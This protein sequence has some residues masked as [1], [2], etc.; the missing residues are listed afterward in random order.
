MSKVIAQKIEEAVFGTK[1]HSQ[2]EPLVV[3]GVDL[4]LWF[5]RTPSPSLHS[6]GSSVSHPLPLPSPSPI[7]LSVPSTLPFGNDSTSIRRVH[8]E[9]QMSDIHPSPSP[10]PSPS[11]SHVNYL[12]DSDLVLSVYSEKEEEE[13][14]KE[15]GDGEG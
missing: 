1:K 3:S 12:F 5:S 8:S 4:Q 15:K 2:N 6:L 7:P 14:K 13:E 9:Q 11:L 10:S